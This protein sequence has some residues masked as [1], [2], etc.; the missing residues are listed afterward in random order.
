[1]SEE[2]MRRFRLFAA[3]AACLISS[4]AYA[5]E[6]YRDE[7]VSFSWPESVSYAPCPDE[8]RSK[9]GAACR[10]IGEDGSLGAVFLTINAGY[11]IGT[12]EALQK[13]LDDSE[14]ALAN[15]P[16][17]HV[18]TT[19]I[20]SESPLMGMIEILRKDGSLNSIAGLQA[21][22]I[23]QTSFILP[24][25]DR[26]AQAF[27]YLPMDDAR[28]PEILSKFT[29]D[30]RSHC[31][32]FQK[33]VIPNETTTASPDGA[34]SLMP[35]AAWTGGIIALIVILIASIQHR[36]RR[37]RRKEED[38][39]LQ[40]QLDACSGEMQFEDGDENKKIEQQTEE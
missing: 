39:K 38:R 23:R 34:L 27:I 8:L 25:G 22:D 13:H 14:S 1:M 10:L 11:A 9:A 29:E 33:P 30:W 21:G 2:V 16:R 20:V 28:S 31:E 18:M 12:A 35:K 24:A 17:I 5:E 3:L 4:F 7:F 26:L 15:I 19:Q 32:V 37:A 6:L 40:M 36:I